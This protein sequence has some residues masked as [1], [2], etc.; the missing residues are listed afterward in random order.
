LTSKPTSNDGSL[1]INYAPFAAVNFVTGRRLPSALL[2]SRS[3]VTIVLAPLS[4]RD[5]RR[6]PGFIYT[7]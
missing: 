4:H 5:R 1:R 6:E 2:E 3:G 7:C